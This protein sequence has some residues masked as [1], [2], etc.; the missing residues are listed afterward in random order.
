ML[1]EI[2]KS[3][4]GYDSFRYGQEEIIQSILQDKDTLV[5]M[6]TGGGKSLCYQLP[7][8]IKQGTALVVSPLI[9]LM[10]DQ[11]DS[12]T[13]ADIPSTFINSSLDFEEIQKRIDW[14]LK[15]DCKLLFI[16]PERLESNRFLEIL[17]SLN[18]SF[19]AVDEAHCISEWGH[20][21]RPSYLSIIKAF[22]NIIRKPIIALTATATPEVQE[23][24][25]KSL[26]MKNPNKFIRGFD[27]PNLSY[28]TI[29]SYDKIE[30]VI[31]IIATTKTGSTIIYCGTRKRVE[32]FA[33]GLNAKNIS[34]LAYHA[35]LHPN[36]RK[37]V[38]EKFINDEAKVIVATN[39]F[40]MGID[41]PDVRN[42]I[43]CDLTLTLEAY[44]QEAGRAG[45]DGKPATCL[46]LFNNDDIDLQ[47][48]FINTNYPPKENI[49]A[50]YNTLYDIN[51]IAIGEYSKIPIF[52]DEASIANRAGVPTY[53][54]ESVLNLL[55]K[56]G[57]LKRTNS[58]GYASIKFT[59][60]REKILDYRKNALGK[61]KEI[62]EALMRHTGPS[63]LEKE[64]DFDLNKFLIKYRIDHLDL[65]NAVNAFELARLLL[66][67]FP[68]T[69]NGF[70]LILERQPFNSVPIDWVAFNQRKKRAF[71]KLEKVIEYANTRECKR[72]FILNYF[73]EQGVSGVCGRCSSC[74]NYKKY[75]KLY[76]EEVNQI[77]KL[78]LLAVA[79]LG[80]RF[81]KKHIVCYL[82]GEETNKTKDYMI[83]QGK[84]FA[85][86][87]KYTKIEIEEAIENA[88]KNSL[89][90]S[91][92]KVSPIELTSQALNIIGKKPDVIPKR[93]KKY[94]N[95][96]N[97]KLFEEL[98]KLRQ[99]IATR[100]NIS[101]YSLIS[102]STLRI[103]VKEKPN[104][105]EAL[106]NISDI[107]K[108]F[109]LRFGKYF[110]AKIND[111]DKSKK[112][113]TIPQITSFQQEIINLL[114]NNTS[115]FQIAEKYNRSIGEIAREV[116]L[117]IQ[118]GAKI[119]L[120]TLISYPLFNKIKK[121]LYK[122]PNINLKQINTILNEDIH[123]AILRI[124]V[125]T[126]KF[127]KKYM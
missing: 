87:K 107:N 1:L 120:D 15:G 46:L 2:L 16:A 76:N 126:I 91:D 123:Y 83:E 116:E 109:L 125:A 10:K 79:E 99:D 110:I 29:N 75:N 39:A 80:E 4:F 36:Y 22:E 119:N 13:K 52:L 117:A 38:Q 102:D 127:N 3:K 64:I 98:L 50:V 88:L 90:K 56:N 95:N 18:I 69:S 26:E 58:Q 7:A 105:L 92:S 122:K 93:T 115:I 82:F 25:I 33:E 72:N 96:D 17:P 71:Q 113:I 77:T 108:A 84:Y 118:T 20:D 62:L 70:Q 6:P 19:L 34:A 12:L 49:E 30:K 55:E 51:N 73:Q 42:V 103:I 48:F 121:L 54:A 45:R 101:E 37:F 89:L 40:G 81:S 74:V 47:V 35:G 94:E 114:N 53:I 65:I 78:V 97:K 68:G 111:Y 31:D 32:Q 21:F 124:I 28:R 24:I 63:A 86:G 43:H 14:L 57:I 85:L 27:R 66:F 44:Y 61:R 23:D 41:K 59:A 106:S 100:E 104:T 5:V 60:S 9:A 8:I 11:V 67:R 112:I